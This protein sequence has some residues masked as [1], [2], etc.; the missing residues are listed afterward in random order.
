MCIGFPGETT[1]EYFPLSGQALGS[2]K[3]STAG[4]YLILCTLQGIT[5]A[6]N[7][8]FN[9]FQAKRSVTERPDQLGTDQRFRRGG[10]HDWNPSW[11]IRWFPEAGLKFK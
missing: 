6:D 9:P 3:L 10:C 8:N 5:G 1:A 11:T 2:F 4:Q 7:S